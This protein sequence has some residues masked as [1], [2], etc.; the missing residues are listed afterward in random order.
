MQRFWFSAAG[1]CGA[2]A[3]ALAAIAAHADLESR[4]MVQN[5]A[6]L[7]G[8]HAPAFIG[9]GLWGRGAAVASV[10]LAGLALFSG[11]VL[12]RAFA[13]VSLGPVAPIGGMTMIGGWLLLAILAWRR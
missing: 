7:L 4:G 12:I 10:L 5:V 6:M 1:L 13:G 3:V 9:L 8:W 11:A 2:L